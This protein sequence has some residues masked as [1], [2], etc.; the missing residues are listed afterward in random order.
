MHKEI[1]IKIFN[2]DT[3]FIALEEVSDYPTSII[4]MFH[5]NNIDEKV[6]VMICEEVLKEK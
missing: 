2:F 3:N 4:T 1:G 6:L 5:K